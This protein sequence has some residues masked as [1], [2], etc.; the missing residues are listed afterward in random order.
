MKNAIKNKCMYNHYKNMNTI[1]AQFC[2]V[3]V[4]KVLGR[5]YTKSSS[6]R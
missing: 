2:I 4:K 6:V 3:S 1:T 5:S